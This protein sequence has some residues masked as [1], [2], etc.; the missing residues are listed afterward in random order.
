[1]DS[2]VPVVL[3]DGRQKKILSRI[4]E[5]EDTG[6]FFM[7]HKNRASSKQGWF[8]DFVGHISSQKK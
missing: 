1:V 7:P 6:T 5:A 2:G 3:A 4:F 8:E